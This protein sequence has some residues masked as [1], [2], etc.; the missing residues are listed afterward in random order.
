[1]NAGLDAVPDVAGVAKPDAASIV[2]IWL[3]KTRKYSSK[4]PDRVAQEVSAAGYDAEQDGTAQGLAGDDLVDHVMAALDDKLEALR[5]NAL[6]Y[7]EPPWG[8]G[9]NGYAAALDS[10][11]VMVD[12]VIEPD[13]CDICEPIPDGNPYTQE[14]LPMWPGDPHPNCRCHITPDDETWQSIFGD[15]AG[16]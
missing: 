10:S 7:S 2:D 6:L 12:W 1:M 15:A 13:A 4:F 3:S 16:D 11:G 5:S 8:A 9:N 14:T